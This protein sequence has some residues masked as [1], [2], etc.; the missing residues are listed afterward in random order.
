VGFEIVHESLASDGDWARYEETA[1]AN[2]ERHGGPESLAYA[3]RIR[4]RR[5]L[6]GGTDTLGFA[7]FVLRRCVPRRVA[8]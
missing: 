2:A 6:P 1:A 7:L 8:A 4:E 5:A 3:R